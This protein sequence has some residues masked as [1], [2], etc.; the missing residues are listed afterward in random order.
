[1]RP[2]LTNPTKRIFSAS[3]SVAASLAA[4]CSVSLL[5]GSTVTLAALLT[6]RRAVAAPPKTDPVAVEGEV[7]LWVPSGINAARVAEIAA[8]ANCEVVYNLNASSRY[9]LLRLK[10]GGTTRAVS[11]TVDTDTKKKIKIGAPSAAVLAAVAS[12]KATQPD[13]LAD[14]NYVRTPSRQQTP[15]TQRTFTP[16]DTYYGEH[17][18]KRMINMPTAWLFQNGTR[19]VLVADIDTGF[20][21]GHPD[22]FRAGVANYINP[23]NTAQLDAMGNPTTTNVAS[24]D[25]HGVH[26]AG[27]IAA[28]TNNGIGVSGVAGYD[29]FG[30]N[31]MLFPIRASVTVFVDGP[32]EGDEPDHFEERF[33]DSAIIVGILQ[34]VAR[35]A[36][37]INMS[38]GGFG[39]SAT[40]GQ[41]V[42]DAIL[43][44]TVIVASTGN[45]SLSADSLPS[46]PANYPGVIAVSAVDN[47]RQLA[48]YSNYG[49]NTT[50]TAPGGDFSGNPNSLQAVADTRILSTFPRTNIN[51]TPVLSEGGIILKAPGYAYLIGT[52]MACPQV[53]G[54]VAL[55]AAGGATGAEIPGIL[56]ESATP[57]PNPTR[58]SPLSGEPIL[59]RSAYGAGLLNVAR[60]LQPRVSLL[61]GELLGQNDVFGNSATDRGSTYFRNQSYDV[62]IGG[63]GNVIREISSGS[64]E[65]SLTYRLEEAT[66]PTAPLQNVVISGSSLSALAA[67]G[68]GESPFAVRAFPLP[69]PAT[70]LG[71]N[72]Y[73]AS[74]TLNYRGVVTTQTQFFEVLDYNQ[75]IGLTLFSVPFKPTRTAL[76]PEEQVLTVGTGFAINRYD[77]LVQEYFRFQPS[78]EP[79]DKSYARFSNLTHS[80]DTRTDITSRLPLLVPLSYGLDNPSVSL[81]PIGVGYWVTLSESRVLD[82]DGTP[83]V[84]PVAIPLFGQ[85][86]RFDELTNISGWNLIGAPFPYPVNWSAVTVRQQTPVGVRDYTLE[87]AIKAE[88]INAQL[89][90]WDVQTRSYF[91]NVAPGGQLLP[92]RAYWVRALR[93][94]TIIVP[95]NRAEQSLTSRAAEKVAAVAA[96]GEGWRVRLSASVAGDRDAE[97]YLGQVRGATEG[98]DRYDV[99]KPPTGPSNAYVRFLNNDRRGRKAAF[100]SDIRPGTAGRQKSE[101]TV[102]VGAGK[103]E[104]DVTVTWDGLRNLPSRARLAIKDTVTGKTV[105]MNGRSSYT[106]KNTEAGA[107]RLFTISLSTQST[108]GPLQIRNVRTVRSSGGRAENRG[109]NV[110]FALSQ[111]ADVR[112]TIRTMTGQIVNDLSGAT[113]AVGQGDVL[114]R[115]N[116]RSREGSEVASG[117]YVLEITARTD[118]GETTTVKRPITYL[119]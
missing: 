33:P 102:A 53:T 84:A 70:R 98:E 94:C 95:P 114:L 109:L 101:W 63:I 22:F 99:P 77:P 41:A 40:Q 45:D 14:P 73:K 68:A 52:S 38:L 97:N 34:A 16:N 43:A 60:A 39:A 118:E 1:M 90:G 26:T 92:F 15:T 62:R 88:I 91:Y 25:G 5:V 13:A 29:G 35:E 49:G 75:P 96:Q 30:V 76:Q 42:A 47:Q 108:A 59:S 7:V 6:A 87:D 86:N 11:G 57:L 2:F 10:N 111:D 78:N 93:D 106:Y 83:A 31:V 79:D 110:R 19:Q 54:A 107:T 80:K 116:G 20:D 71:Q 69:L 46:F 37:A 24:P 3:A 72:R 119:Q 113:R 27:T 112:A 82:T 100:A 12:I 65:S 67:L 66:T 21:V 89:V 58:V 32:D 28:V 50:I 103:G 74:L 8:A 18:D 23:I 36:V 105:S 56:T 48:S 44:G 55:L 85:E 61:G 17:W 9:Y 117:P 81:A 51:G 104:T 64:G 115:W 4:V